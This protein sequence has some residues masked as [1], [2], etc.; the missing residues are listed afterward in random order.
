M[1][2]YPRGFV[3]LR[4]EPLSRGGSSLGHADPSG[5]CYRL[6]DMADSWLL[7]FRSLWSI[8]R[9]SLTICSTTRNG[10]EFSCIKFSFKYMEINI[11]RVISFIE[12][13]RNS[14]IFSCE[15]RKKRVAILSS[16]SIQKIGET[17]P[18]KL[19][20]DSSRYLY[21]LSRYKNLKFP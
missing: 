8:S 1:P 18:L 15:K 4:G 12:N 19:L 6:I 14:F 2:D 17:V 10:D 20:F 5:E 9:C 13:K 3:G 16:R 7:T 21:S 11:N